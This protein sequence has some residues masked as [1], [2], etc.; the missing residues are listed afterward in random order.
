MIKTDNR[1]VVDQLT[2]G[3]IMKFTDLISPIVY[4]VE[5]INS[6]ISSASTVLSAE[7]SISSIKS[8][9]DH[10]LNE[11]VDDV[12]L[13]KKKTELIDIA[14]NYEANK[15]CIKLVKNFHKRYIIL[16]KSNYVL[17]LV[18]CDSTKK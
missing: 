5:D 18:Q 7:T 17:T 6:S 9:D 3:E 4:E 10:S 2:C 8:S 13:N 15:N 14:K 11:K 12:E 16:A 1:P